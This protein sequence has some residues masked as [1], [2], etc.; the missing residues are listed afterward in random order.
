MIHELQ[1]P[2]LLRHITGVKYVLSKPELL[3]M[4]HESIRKRKYF[5]AGD[6]YIFMRQCLDCGLPVGGILLLQIK[7][8]HY[9]LD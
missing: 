5:A 4:I 9:A 1:D 8:L 3:S 7:I 6:P 2:L